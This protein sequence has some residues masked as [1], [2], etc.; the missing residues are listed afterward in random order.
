MPAVLLLAAGFLMAPA[1]N[2]QQTSSQTDST[3]VYKYVEHMPQFQGGMSAMMEFLSANITH[4]GS[5]APGM[6]LLS[7]VVDKDGS[8]GDTHIIKSL[9]PAQDVASIN[10]VEAMNGRWTPGMQDGKKVPV[11]FTLPI[12]F[13]DARF[14][15]SNPEAMPEY[16]GGVKAFKAFMKEHVKQP[17][18][19]AKHGTVV[20]SFLINE[21]GSLSDYKLVKSVDTVLDEEALRLAKL[22]EGN[23]LAPVQ[24]NQKVKVRYNMPVIF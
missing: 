12:K 1:A 20:V 14:E 15:K 9:S 8:I 13:G 22:T 18:R 3:K 10:A 6:V 19:T 17:K 7:F 24:D 2:A 16:K 5:Q 11:R 21:D 4:T 23:W